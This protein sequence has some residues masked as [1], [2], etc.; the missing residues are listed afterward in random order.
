MQLPL[1]RKSSCFIYSDPFYL[2][3]QQHTN[4]VIFEWNEVGTVNCPSVWVW[5]VDCFLCSLIS[6][7]PEANMEHEWTNKVN[8]W[9]NSKHVCRSEQCVRGE[10]QHWWCCRTSL[11]RQN[12]VPTFFHRHFDVKQVKVAEQIRCGFFFEG[13]ADLYFDQSYI[14]KVVSF[15]VKI[16]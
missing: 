2:H 5:K 13:A 15:H 14:T 9:M 12:Q 8:E 4:K 1:C 11:K 7:K 16:L 6:N 10:L 3:T